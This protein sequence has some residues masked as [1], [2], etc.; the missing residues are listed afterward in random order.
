MKPSEY[1]SYLSREEARKRSGRSTRSTF[2]I[3]GLI[4]L[5][6]AL[7]CYFGP[8]IDRILF[9]TQIYLTLGGAVVAGIVGLWLINRNIW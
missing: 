1:E 7:I 4:C 5:F 8:D 3:V 6:V 9:K 2:I